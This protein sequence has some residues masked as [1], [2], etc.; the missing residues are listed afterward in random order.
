ME[1]WKVNVP[2][3]AHC[4]WLVGY[5]V[6]QHI[7]PNI[8]DRDNLVLQWLLGSLSSPKQLLLFQL[9]KTITKTATTTTTSTKTTT[10][11]TT[12]WKTSYWI[13]SVC[14][15]QLIKE[16]WVWS[17][18]SQASH[19]REIFSSSS[20]ISPISRL[21]WW[22]SVFLQ[23]LPSIKW[24]CHVKRHHNLRTNR[25]LPLLQ[26]EWWPSKT[27]SIPL[28]FPITGLNGFLYL[29]SNQLDVEEI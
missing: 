13:I 16:W 29:N 21:F 15:G 22:E 2:L 9:L 18:R 14:L 8:N 27:R 23:T 25:F 19:L 3:L 6:D 17:E 24:W 28:P 26:S 12:T 4:C 5:W 11:K 7:K 20:N 10:M 1:N